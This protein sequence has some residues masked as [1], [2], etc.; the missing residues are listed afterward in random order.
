[1]LQKKIL[2]TLSEKLKTL[3][4]VC[5]SWTTP[6][7]NFSNTIPLLLVLVP[8][9]GLV[10]PGTIWRSHQLSATVKAVQMLTINFTLVWMP[11]PL[12]QTSSHS[13]QT[14]TWAFQLAFDAKCTTTTKT[15]HTS[16]KSDSCCHNYR[17]C[18]LPLLL[19]TDILIYDIWLNPIHWWANLVSLTLELG[20]LCY[21]AA[22][23]FVRGQ[24]LLV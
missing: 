10:S 16:H 18:S 17:I 11:C 6:C 1:M 14:H 7:F 22:I 23:V 9:Q 4:S 15:L 19:P 13:V 5:T 3:G 2:V 20:L 21:S 24:L 8:S 12:F